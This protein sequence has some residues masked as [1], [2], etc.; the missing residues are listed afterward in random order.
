MAKPHMESKAYA[1]ITP[2]PSRG[3]VVHSKGQY[4]IVNDGMPHAGFQLKWTMPLPDAVRPVEGTHQ[5]MYLLCEV[6]I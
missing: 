2:K 3:S 1:G 4:S 5:E 6:Q